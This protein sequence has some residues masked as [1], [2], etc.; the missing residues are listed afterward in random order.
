MA[1]PA[2]S[3]ITCTALGLIVRGTE[4]PRRQR[5]WG[6]RSAEGAPLGPVIATTSGG[7]A[8]QGGD[9]GPGPSS[10][11]ARALRL[12]ADVEGRDAEGERVHLQFCKAP[13]GEE[14]EHLVAIGELEHGLGQVM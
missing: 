8:G 7:S 13:Q 11:I 12:G 3:R 1:R 4:R 10:V 5:G 6:R 14:E 9:S 2:S